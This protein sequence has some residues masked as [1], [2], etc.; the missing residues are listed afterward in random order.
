MIEYY[1][2][3]A[4]DNHV[5]PDEN[6]AYPIFVTDT[7]RYRVKIG[8]G[9]RTLADLPIISSNL[10]GGEGNGSVIQIDP[11][12]DEGEDC[13]CA[14][15]IATG[16]LSAAF[17]KYNEV[18]G[19]ASAAFGYNNVI[20]EDAVKSFV[21]GAANTLNGARTLVLAYKSTASGAGAG[22][23]G[24]STNTVESNTGTVIGGAGNKLLANAT[25]AIL[26]GRGLTSDVA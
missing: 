13:Y 4:S 18:Y 24:G 22:I 14:P 8:D 25:M 21:A 17:G 16:Q 9:E 2:V 26:A 6:G 19:K 15:S 3:N 7:V 10:Q 12:Y 23:F 1:H 5:E 11:T 20:N